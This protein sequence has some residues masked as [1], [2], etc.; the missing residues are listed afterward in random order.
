MA[1]FDPDFA[2]GTEE[3]DA[4]INIDEYTSLINEDPEK[5]KKS[6][7]KRFGSRAKKAWRSLI[8]L[9][10]QRNP[11]EYTKYSRIS[12]EM[13][14]TTDDAKD[15]ILSEY[16]NF[17]LDN[18]RLTEDKGVIK[19]EV[20]YFGKD[21]SKKW[22]DKKLFNKSQ[23]LFNKNGTLSKHVTELE[24]FKRASLGLLQAASRSEGLKEGIEKTKKV[25]EDRIV[26][27]EKKIDE[28]RKKCV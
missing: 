19:I 1:E 7:I 6:F 24:A 5:V 26:G 23:K 3:G 15:R 28:M 16:P 21:K 4:D 27:Y 8:E 11:E 14:E 22:T 9:V 13:N 18:I 25:Y 20:K 12:F 17:R 2:S 10:K